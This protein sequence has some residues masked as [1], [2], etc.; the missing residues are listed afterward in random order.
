MVVSSKLLF[1][2]GYLL[3]PG[4]GPDLCVCLSRL[5]LFFF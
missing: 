1:A 5:G 2:A 4:K 3:S